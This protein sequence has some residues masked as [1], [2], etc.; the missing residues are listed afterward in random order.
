M[1]LSKINPIT[2]YQLSFPRNKSINNNS[3]DREQLDK[4]S[5]MG[6]PDLIKKSI[7][8]APEIKSKE[9][10]IELLDRIYKYR[11]SE[12]E[13]IYNS[14]FNLASYP[15]VSKE[16]EGILLYAGTSDLSGDINRYLSGRQMTRMSE[17]MAR[18][19]ISVL[20]YSLK[21][22]DNEFGR[23][24]G[25]VYRQGFFPVDGEQFISSTSVPVIGAT[26]RG[27]ICANPKMNFSIIQTKNGHRIDKFQYKMGSEYAEEEEEIL[28][29]RHS[30]Y[31]EVLNPQG[32][33]RQEKEKFLRMLETYG[34]CP[35]NSSQ[36][37]IF[38]EI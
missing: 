26:L 4:I 19:V 34:H 18:D 29:S 38:E 13:L 11:N 24:S 5:F 12:N 30:K 6:Y 10:Y 7:K 21:N 33:Y 25:I 15:N 28:L 36:V 14:Q 20:D 17:D 31:R 8:L 35:I 16:Q 32:R 27:G 9:E 2:S 1:Q 22:L 37:R 3:N 23:Y